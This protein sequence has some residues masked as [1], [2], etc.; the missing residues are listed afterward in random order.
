MND[1]PNNPPYNMRFVSSPVKGM[2]MPGLAVGDG[3]GGLG[4]AVGDGGTTTGS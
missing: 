3:F 4:V 1:I 2:M